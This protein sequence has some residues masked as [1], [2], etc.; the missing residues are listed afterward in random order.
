MGVTYN[1]GIIGGSEP[2]ERYNRIAFEVGRL[3][4][5]RGAIVV[6]GGLSGVMESAARGAFESGGLTVGILPGFNP[7]EGNSYLTV[8]LPTGIG[9]ARNFLIVRAS[10]ALI[11]I[12]GSNG[13]LSEASFAIAEGKSVISIDGFELRRGKPHEGRFIRAE[14]AAD[15][16]EAALNEAAQYRGHPQRAGDR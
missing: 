16:V 4:A 8:R 9:Y 13:T 5:M 15:A 1:I 3:L 12:D 14:N 10:D 7:S 11:A 2:E 6:C